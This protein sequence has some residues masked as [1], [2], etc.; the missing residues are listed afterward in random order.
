MSLKDEPGHVSQRRRRG[1]ELEGAL[2]DAAWAE[3]LETGY[4]ALT[5]DAVAERARTSRAV[6]Y[7][8]WPNK[9]EL[10]LAAVAR[11][12]AAQPVPIPDTG[13]LRGDMIALLHSANDTRARLAVQLAARLDGTGDDAITLADLRERLS[14]RSRRLQTVLER[15]HARGEIP[16]VDL[17]KRVRDVPFE[18]LGY[19]VLLAQ[20]AAT[21]EEIVEIVDDVFLPLARLPR[22]AR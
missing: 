13:S 18:V 19:H 16:T 3:L 6:L 15:A 8:R 1:V 10:A 21:A 7:R 11:V 12:L 5:Y 4:E 9:R 14:S 2:L 22:D 17:P 20:R